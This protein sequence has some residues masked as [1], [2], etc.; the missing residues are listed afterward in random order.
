MRRRRTIVG[1]EVGLPRPPA[2]M[3]RGH[4]RR[5][6]RRSRAPIVLLLALL[7]V[8]AVVALGRGMAG[9]GPPSF[10]GLGAERA[11]PAG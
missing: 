10:A 1:S 3:R 5:A 6:G 4:T 8:L 7:L 11:A 2:W 9:A